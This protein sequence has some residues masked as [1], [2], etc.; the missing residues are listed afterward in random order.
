MNKSKIIIHYIVNANG[1]NSIKIRYYQVD[2]N[3]NP[4][5]MSFIKIQIKVENKWIGKEMPIFFFN[6]RLVVYEMR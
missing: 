2:Q 5:Y 4:N 6:D 3:T 1:L